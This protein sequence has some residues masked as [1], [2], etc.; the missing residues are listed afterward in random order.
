MRPQSGRLLWR[1]RP[2][3]DGEYGLGLVLAGDVICTGDGFGNIYGL[4]AAAGTT[5]WRRTFRGNSSG[6]LP[7]AAAGGR[8]FAVG[9]GR[10]AA[11]SAATGRQLWS[12][13]ASGVEPGFPPGPSAY[14]VVYTND[15]VCVLG[16]DGH[17]AGLDPRTGRQLWRSASA[18]FGG[19]R[20]QWH[21][22]NA[23][24]GRIAGRHP[25][26]RYLVERLIPV[27]GA[28]REPASASMTGWG[29][30]AFFVPL[31]LYAAV[32]SCAT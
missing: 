11:L 9:S 14:F 31:Q 19:A 22:A 17:A 2:F 27:G 8:V 24:P 4:N 32:A 3:V 12:V 7:L 30:A 28:R 23:R 1:S 5:L 13:P 26:V 25:R 16:A 10:V 6:Y 18:G 20:G 21:G 15:V 29:G